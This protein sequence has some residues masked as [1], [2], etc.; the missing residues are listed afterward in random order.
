[1]NQSTIKLGS[2]AQIKTVSDAWARQLRTFDDLYGFL[3]LHGPSMRQPL[4]VL[5]WTLG[6]Y[7]A[8]N[9]ELHDSEDAMET[10]RAY[11][12]V[13][14]AK[15]YMRTTAHRIVYSVRGA[16]PPARQGQAGPATDVLIRLKVARRPGGA[17]GGAR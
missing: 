3:L 15:V 16:L 8:L 11:A 7:Y 9:A 10:L 5:E 4:P 12:D 17:S 2:G 1:M 6:G 14:G 13:L